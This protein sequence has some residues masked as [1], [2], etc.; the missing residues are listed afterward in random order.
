MADLAPSMELSK[1]ST[2]GELQMYGY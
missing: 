2:L 1:R